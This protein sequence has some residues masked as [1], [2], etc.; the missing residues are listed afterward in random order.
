M[1]KYRNA[2]M[3][4]C[5][6]IDFVLARSAQLGELLALQHNFRGK[7][8]VEMPCLGIFAMR[9]LGVIIRVGA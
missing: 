5:V 6:A 9:Q 8:Q 2:L 4:I 1:M 3:M 7:L